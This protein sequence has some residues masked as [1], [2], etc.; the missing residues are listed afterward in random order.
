[1]WSEIR[2]QILKT[3]QLLTARMKGVDAGND[4]FTYLSS[5]NVLERVSLIVE[6]KRAGE[7]KPHC[8]SSLNVLERVSLIVKFKRAGEGK[9]H[10][11]SSLNMLERVSLIVCQ[12]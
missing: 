12:V 9:P 7:G 3:E 11:V 10:C 8:L 6:F 5:L 4:F 2:Q 1:M